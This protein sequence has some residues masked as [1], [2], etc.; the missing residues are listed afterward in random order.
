VPLRVYDETLRVLRRAVDRAKL[1]ED[2]RMAA[3]RRLDAEARRLE[4]AARGR[5]FEEMV[6]EE[7]LAS[8]AY[9]GRSVVG[10]GRGPPAAAGTGAGPTVPP[11][12]T[13]TRKTS[14]ARPAASPRAQLP[15]SAADQ[16]AA[17]SRASSASWRT[18][19]GQ[20]IEASSAVP[21]QRASSHSSQWASSR[22]DTSATNAKF[23]CSPFEPARC[24]S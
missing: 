21:T 3:I 4:R 13:P 8:A 15:S 12:S 24:S 20:G 10:E 18:F 7:R 2:D 19:S 9:G 11:T 23:M 6:A 17:I 16:A 1:G 5:G 14:G 22:D